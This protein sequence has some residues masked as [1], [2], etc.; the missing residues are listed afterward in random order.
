MRNSVALMEITHTWFLPF[1]NKSQCDVSV[2][3]FLFLNYVA[4]AHFF[5]AKRKSE[6]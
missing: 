3:N 1:K 4:S 2:L 6:D 5:L